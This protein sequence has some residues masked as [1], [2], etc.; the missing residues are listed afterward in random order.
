MTIDDQDARRNKEP[1]HGRVPAPR[2]RVEPVSMG[3]VV[4]DHNLDKAVQLAARL[5]DY[6]IARRLRM[7]EEAA[8]DLNPVD[9]SR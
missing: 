7:R 8:R 3:G 6:E 9:P 2:Y 1:P 4:G 5:E